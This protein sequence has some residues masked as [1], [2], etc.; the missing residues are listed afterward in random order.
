MPPRN[1]SVPDPWEDADTTQS[2]VAVLHERSMRHAEAIAEHDSALGGIMRTL[3]EIEGG[4]KTLKWLVPI[5]GGA[6]VVLCSVVVAV[7]T[8]WR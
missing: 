7:V 5:V 4:I 1:G 3:G 8:H 2:R 6:V